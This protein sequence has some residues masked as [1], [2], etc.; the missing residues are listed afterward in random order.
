[1]RVIKGDAY[2]L[3]LPDNS[4]DIVLNCE[5][6]HAYGDCKRFMR[7]R[8]RSVLDKK[9]FVLQE[10]LRVLRPGGYFCWADFRFTGFFTEWVY[11]E[12]HDAGLQVRLLISFLSSLFLL[13]SLSLRKILREAFLM[14]WTYRL[15]AT[16]SGSIASGELLV[17]LY[18]FHC[19]DL[20]K[21]LQVHPFHEPLLLV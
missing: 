5:A 6:S 16:K 4:V 20:Q 9:T 11:T 17:T 14:H 15:N 3:P 10:V 1:M 8:L 21:T 2:A 13:Y 19:I 18:I 7:V 12:A